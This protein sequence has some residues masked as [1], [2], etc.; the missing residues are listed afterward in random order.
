MSAES[1]NR[2][3]KSCLYALIR[4]RATR[5]KISILV[6]G[7]SL[8]LVPASVASCAPPMVSIDD[9]EA[10]PGDEIRVSGTAW[11]SGCED[12]GGSAG[13][14][15][16]AAESS[17]PLQNIE[18]RLKGP[19]TD[20]TQKQLDVGAIGETEV[21]LSLGEV[22]ADDEGSF[23][24]SITIPDVAAGRYFIT[25]ISELPAYQPPEIAIT[26]SR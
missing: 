22:D 19:R 10:A 12:T 9:F 7:L 11:S 16:S 14:C 1:L 3:Q 15:A 6:A 8:S 21:D 13:G 4:M 17:K 25:A 5:V 23:T 2:E 20:Q 18:L 24:A 26:H